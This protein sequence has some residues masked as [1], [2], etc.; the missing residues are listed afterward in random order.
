MKPPR[1]FDSPASQVET[2]PTVKTPSPLRWSP[3]GYDL[4]LE[5][6]EALDVQKFNALVQEF[7]DAVPSRRNARV[8]SS[9]RRWAGDARSALP[10]SECQSLLRWV[11]TSSWRN[12]VP[13]AE[14][15]WAHLFGRPAPTWQAWNGKRYDFDHA[16][17]KQWYGSLPH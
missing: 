13:A 1:E 14:A 6:R 17:W 2:G 4:I 15:L 11:I 3:R 9:L 12:A 5:N 10:L 16:A 7:E 8:V